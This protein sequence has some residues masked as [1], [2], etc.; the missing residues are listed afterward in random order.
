MKSSRTASKN[1]LHPLES[2]GNAH[3]AR[4]SIRVERL[5]DRIEPRVPFPHKHDFY[6]LVVVTAGQGFHEIDFTKHPVKRGQFFNMKPEQ[7]HAWKLKRAQGFVIEFTHETLP[8]LL[9]RR[10]PDVVTIRSD[11]DV[12]AIANLCLVM[13]EEF[14]SARPHHQESLTHL[15]QTLMIHF[16]NAAFDTTS[17]PTADSFTS[18]FQTLVEAH[19]RKE[20][21]VEFYA[22]ELRVTAKALTMR[23]SRT[24]GQSARTY[25]LRRVLLEAKRLLSQSDQTIA[26]VGYELGFDD[27]NYF[28]RFFHD[29]AK[30]NPSDFR[31]QARKRV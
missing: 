3:I 25:V 23:I 26:D 8:S 13:L 20:R 30:M 1:R 29:Y 15:L 31:R 6:Q 28:T 2:L 17:Q 24:L 10:L 5:E 9:D 27:P 19:Y 22:K 11:R 16:E 12:R 7:V 21:R 18:N 14:E 4:G